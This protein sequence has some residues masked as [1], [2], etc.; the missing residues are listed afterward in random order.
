MQTVLC[1]SFISLLDHCLKYAKIV[2]VNHTHTNIFELH[3][4]DFIIRCL[5]TLHHHV[6]KI[7]KRICP[8]VSL[9]YLIKFPFWTVF[10]SNLLSSLA[11]LRILSSIP[12]CERILYIWIGII[13][14][15]IDLTND[16]FFQNLSIE[17]RISVHAGW[18]IIDCISFEI[19][20]SFNY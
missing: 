13:E 11:F 15:L 17:I 7:V 20:I 6:Y 1:R 4:N 12:T 14:L 8:H 5:K 3:L 10:I 2:P 9:I 16:I 19:H 18:I